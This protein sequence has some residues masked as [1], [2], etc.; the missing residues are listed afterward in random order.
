MLDAAAPALTLDLAATQH[1]YVQTSKDSTPQGETDRAEPLIIVPTGSS[2]TPPS[3]VQIAPLQA[4]PENDITSLELTFDDPDPLD[5]HTVEVDWGDGSTE[6]FNVPAGSQFFGTTHQY[7]DD[8]PSVT[9][10]DT[11]IVKATVTDSQGGSASSSTPITVNNVAPSNLQIAPILP[12]NEN[13]VASLELTFDDPGTIDTHQV[14][15]NWGDGSTELFNVSQGARFFGTTHQFLDDNPS[16]TTFDIYSVKVRVLDD[17][18]G[19]A[20]ATV[21]ALVN[22][23]APSNLQIGALGT[24]NENGLAQ[25]NLSFDDPGSLDTHTVQVDWGD[26]SVESFNLSQGARLFGTTHQYL[27]DNP[28]ATPSDMYT[29]KVTVADDDGGQVSG[30]QSITVNNVAPSGIQ[31]D[32]VTPIDE[33]GVAMMNLSFTDPGTLDTHT[34]QVDWGDGSAVETLPVAAG[35]RTLAASHQYLDDNPTG[36]SSDNYTIKVSV[37]DDDTGEGTAMT[38]VTVSNVPPSAIVITPLSPVDENG[39]AMLNL[40]FTDP[41]TL[42][43]H[44]VEVDWGDGSALQTLPVAAGAR[45]FTANHQYLDDNPTGTPSDVYMVKVR[46]LDD[47]GGIGIASAPITVNNVAPFNVQV[48]PSSPTVAEGNLVSLAFTFD[49]PGTLDTHTYQV[50]WGDGTAVTVGAA[51]GHSF[52]AS[53]T[54]ADNGTYAVQVAVTDD[55]SGVGLGSASV[56]VTNVSPS[57]TVVGNQTVNEGS[58]L[59]LTNIGTFTD[60]G[61]D[62]PLNAGNVSNGGETVESFTYSINWGDGTAMSAGN[63]TVD[64]AGSAGVLTAGSFDGS[65]TFADNGNYTITVTVFD[66]D[67]GQDQKS[68]QVAVLNVSP[69]LA[70]VSNQTINEGSLL[71]LTN[72]G[73]FTDPG[74][75]NPLNTLDPNNG[76]ETVETF[77]F[78]VNWGDGT[79]TDA[80]NATVDV[81]G[82]PGVLTAGS[83]DGSHTYA[84]NGTY[85][86][87]VKVF[88]D[89]GGSDAKTFQVSV[90]NVAPLLSAPVNQTI[91][92]GS[93]LTLTNIGSFTDPGFDNPLNA[94]NA[95]NGGETVETFTFTVNWGDGTATDSGNGTIDVHGSP[96]TLTAGSFDGSHTY[97]DN[98]NYTV[99]VTVF[100][101][102]GGQDQTTFTVNVLNVSPALSVV[103]SQTIDE[104]S[105]LSL[106]NIGTFTDPGFDNPLNAGNA[107]NG[108]ETVETF[109]FSTDWGDGTAANTG[110]A[111]IDV[112]GSVGVL[113]AGSFDGSHTY[114]DN[115][116]YTVAVTVFDDDGGQ[117]QQTFT[118]TVLNVDPTL[119]GTSGLVRDEGQAFTLAGLG[120]RIEDPG[121]DNPLNAG[122]ASN[123]GEFEETFAGVTIDWGDGTALTPVTTVNRVSGSPGVPT[124]ADFDHAPHTYADNG[125]YTVT[126]KLSDD[127]GPVDSRTLTITVNNVAPT[128]QVAADQTIHE[129]SQLVVLNISQFTDPGFDNP[130][131]AGNVTN[132]GQ[133]QETFTYTINW[134]DQPRFQPGDDPVEQNGVPT[135]DVFGSPGV[136]TAGSFDAQHTYVDNGV[137]TVTI[138]IRDDDGGVTVKTLSVDVKNVSP[139]LSDATFF[140]TDVNTKGQ[141][142]ITGTFTD[143][144]RDT[145][146]LFVDWGDNKGPHEETFTVTPAAATSGLHMFTATHTYTEAPDPLHPSAT[147]PIVVR[148]HD[149][150]FPQPQTVVAPPDESGQS[151]PVDRDLKNPGIGNQFI[152]IDLTPAVAVLTF[153][154]RPASPPVL[155]TQDT[156]LATLAPNDVRGS[157]GESQAAGERYFE[158]RVINPDGT[159]SEGYRLRPEVMKNLPGLFRNLPDNHYAIYLVQPENNKSRLVIEVVVRNGKLVDPGDDSEGGRDKPPTEDAKPAAE[160]KPP[161]DA[162]PND[163][164]ANK[165]AAKNIQPISPINEPVPAATSAIDAVSGTNSVDDAIQGSPRMRSSSTIYHRAALAGAA[166]ALSG[167]GRDWQRQLDKTLAAAKPS[168]WK[169]LRAARGRSRKKPR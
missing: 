103:G 15:V 13:G 17:D 99:T 46:V 67:G 143:P 62:N 96:G 167:A 74:F 123:G 109:T 86:V 10:A 33:N 34:V 89:D 8:N 30:A 38:S 49:D 70:V 55:D 87:T 58:L 28:T 136:L 27:D 85:T 114:A 121:F 42:D 165:A 36:T 100:D 152:R 155:T 31:L 168:Q 117:H 4:I 128:V 52:S 21:P 126:V 59:S 2:N 112:H 113:T 45:T 19:E 118:V 9:P 110:D 7:L 48:T 20:S 169:R 138:T 97:A 40:S 140:A 93:L 64:I 127:D 154:E 90:L 47:D 153:P 77:T 50:N 106:T 116:T 102:D 53:H 76:G 124:T 133:T 32:P 43:T 71:S 139:T 101:D 146:K 107:S 98:G 24:I 41:G 95:A 5:S 84:D 159:M 72:I 14:E 132:G 57:L 18:G 78:T 131:N 158:L 83:F 54:Y 163:A 3:N 161:T 105:L 119:T 120:V 79:S 115:G 160:L 141:T 60:P 122:N 147:I 134:G 81:I 151:N 166:L 6:L 69:T 75:D 145:Y 148:I 35:A 11:Y 156:R 92:E 104:G 1:D 39:V 108:G 125:V 130:L 56:T 23:V 29:V 25:L 44:M 63:A 51:A 66:D 157:A 22:N 65:H 150:D 61:F 68:F 144:G 164:G 149:D 162:N 16:G 94:G 26:G 91:N 12:V 135:T 111:T 142:T 73:T 88:D 37:I 80:G 129:G 137:Y 82:S